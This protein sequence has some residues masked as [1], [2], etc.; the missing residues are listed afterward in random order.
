MLENN[1]NI[2]LCLFMSF[3]I[4]SYKRLFSKENVCLGEQDYKLILYMFLYCVCTFDSS[5]LHTVKEYDSIRN[6]ISASYSFL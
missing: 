5:V 2:I 4:R 1:L 3:C 6:I